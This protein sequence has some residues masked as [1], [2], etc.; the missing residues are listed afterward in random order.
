MKVGVNV[1]DKQRMLS[2]FKNGASV[3]EVSKKLKVKADVI[4]TFAKYYTDKKTLKRAP[5]D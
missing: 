4:Q 1:Q 5:K 3:S 2:M